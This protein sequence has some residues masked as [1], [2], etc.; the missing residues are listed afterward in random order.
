[1]LLQIVE[2]QEVYS[3]EEKFILQCLLTISLRTHLNQKGY[4]KLVD[5]FL[6][7]ELTEILIFL[8]GLETLDIRINR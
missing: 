1:M 5:K 8:E 2:I 7:E 6:A 4:K 3:A